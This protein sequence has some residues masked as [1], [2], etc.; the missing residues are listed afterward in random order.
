M[1][2]HAESSDGEAKFWLDPAIELAKNYR[3]SDREVRRIRDI[4][5]SREQ[6]IRNAWN[7]HFGG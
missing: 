7:R 3:L 1:H 6:E 4:I 2:V 5:V